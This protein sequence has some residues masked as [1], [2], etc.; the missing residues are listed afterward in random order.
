METR[1]RGN[2][3]RTTMVCIDSYE[4]SV[5]VGRFYNP[6]MDAPEQFHSLMDFLLKV[7]AMLDQMKF[8]QSFQLVRSFSDRTGADS[9]MAEDGVL[10]GKLA[11]FAVKILFRQNSSWQGTVTWLEGHMDESFRSVLELVLLM[12]SALK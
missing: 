6:Y 12:D 5:P 11:T 8:P 2:E 4:N 1:V 9:I 10:E 7:Q 3:Y